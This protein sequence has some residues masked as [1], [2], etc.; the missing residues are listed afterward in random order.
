MQ[1]LG[2]PH[3]GVPKMRIVRLLA[4][5]HPDVR[6]ALAELRAEARKG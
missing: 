1:A 5:K 3:G 2:P 6:Q 4:L